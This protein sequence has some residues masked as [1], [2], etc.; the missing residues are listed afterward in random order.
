MRIND[1]L[2]FSLE[3]VLPERLARGLQG[4]AYDTRGP[5]YR[6]PGISNIRDL[7][8]RKAQA[9][10]ENLD[11]GE[12]GG[13]SFGPQT[14]RLMAQALHEIRSDLPELASDEDLQRV[15]ASILKAAA[16]GERDLE[17]LKS[18]AKI[19]IFVGASTAP[20]V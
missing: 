5:Q 17:R 2:K 9:I 13:P 15:A 12:F 4:L 6:S 8:L 14:M 7:D 11:H 18:K 19:T 10:I 1:L 20:K 3:L 16:D